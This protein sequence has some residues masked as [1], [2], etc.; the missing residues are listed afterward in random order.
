VI[1]DQKP[2][3][4]DDNLQ[5]LYGILMIQVNHNLLEFPKPVENVR[6]FCLLELTKD[7]VPNSAT[8][9]QCQ[10]K[11]GALCSAA[12]TIASA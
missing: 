2:P 12:R 11:S 5:H 6:L 9:K 8:A 4:V 10:L 3:I 1:V 7:Q